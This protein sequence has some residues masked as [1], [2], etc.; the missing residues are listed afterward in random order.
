M[1]WERLEKFSGFPEPYLTAREAHYRRW[2][3]IYSK[4]LIREDIRD[5]ANIKAISDLETLYHMLPSKVGSPLS[6]PSLEG[7]LKVAHNTIRTWLSTFEHF[8]LVFSVTPWTRKIARAI[9]KERK[10]YL[11]DTPRI[12]EPAARLENMVAL[13]LYRAVTLWSDLGWGDYSS[14]FIKNKE[15]QEVDFL[16]ADENRPVILIETKLSDTQ[17]S[18]ALLKFQSALK[19][20][21]VQLTSRPGGFRVI[22]N[23]NQKLLIAP[24]WQ[25]LATL[26]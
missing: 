9:Q 17:P 4:Q 18:K 25:W 19:I 6:I 8:F 16:I 7:D 23:N 3:N 21:A 26:P 2:P 11:W 13:E 12:K 20:P 10:I 15:R 24:A 5:L 14:H 1:I 22:S